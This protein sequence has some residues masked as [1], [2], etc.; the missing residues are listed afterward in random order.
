[1]NEQ[2]PHLRWR[3]SPKRLRLCATSRS[4]F[5]I[6]LHPS[7]TPIYTQLMENGWRNVEHAK[8]TNKKTYE[9]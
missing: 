1:M 4:H 8:Q 7:I 9:R 6:F 3:P 2:N 5:P